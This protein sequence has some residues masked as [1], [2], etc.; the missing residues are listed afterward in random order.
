MK[1]SFHCQPNGYEHGGAFDMPLVFDWDEQSGAI[2]GPGAVAIAALRRVGVVNYG[3]HPPGQWT[4]AEGAPLSATDLAAIVGHA[5]CVPEALLPHYPQ[6]QDAYEMPEATYV[7]EHGVT[8]LG[9]DLLT[10]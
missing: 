10:Y 8:V 3:P 5:W 9:R 1:H 7:D 2:T 4:F 6:W